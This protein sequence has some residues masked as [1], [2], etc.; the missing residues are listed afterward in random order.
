MVRGSE[1]HKHSSVNMAEILAHCQFCFVT[2]K[3]VK[4][5]CSLDTTCICPLFLVTDLESVDEV[6]N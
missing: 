6:S 3:G 5:G 1:F 4:F 2:G